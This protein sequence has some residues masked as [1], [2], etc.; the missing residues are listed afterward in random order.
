MGIRYYAYAFDHE[1]TE[2]ALV[3]PRSILSDDPLA[4][5]WGL[6]PGAA[7]S[8]A[9]FEQTVP[10]R[11]MLYLDKAWQEL[12]YLTG[13]HLPGGARPSYRMFEGRVTMQGYGWIP[14]V[15]ALHPDEMP[16]IARDLWAI[17]DADAGSDTDSYVV[18]YLRRAQAFASGLAAEGRGAVYMIG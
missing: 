8:V 9:T 2:Q 10:A 3:D 7:V 5:A 1:L 4:D 11:D 12:Q 16:A 14:W 6:E 13:P 15:R 18:P 17:E